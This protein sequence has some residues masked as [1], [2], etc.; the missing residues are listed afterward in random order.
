MNCDEDVFR[1]HVDGPRTRDGD[2]GWN[3]GRQGAHLRHHPATVTLENGLELVLETIREC[4][5]ATR[6]ISPPVE[7]RV[8]QDGEGFVYKAEWWT[9]WIIERPFQDTRE[10]LEYVRRHLDRLANAPENSMF[11]F[12]GQGDVWARDAVDPNEEYRKLQDKLDNVVLF[13]SESPVGLDT[14]YHRAGMEPSSSPNCWRPSIGTRSGGSI[15]S[16]TRA[17]PPSR[18]FT[19]IWRTRTGRCSHPN[20]F[21]SSSSRD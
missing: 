1:R 2:P 11:T 16:R 9:L 6:G 13:P 18:W 15:A 10:Y 7:E 4:L 8:W 21:A 14:A 17:W 5:D 20:S 19:R 12:Y 3:A